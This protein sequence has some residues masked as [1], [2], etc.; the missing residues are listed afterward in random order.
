MKKTHNKDLRFTKEDWSGNPIDKQD[1]YINLDGP[2]ARGF[3]DVYQWKSGK[4]KYAAQKKDQRSNVKVL[5]NTGFLT[6]SESHL[7]WL[8]HATFL[9]QFDGL[10]VITDPILY[11]IWPLKRFTDLPCQPEE[12]IDI[13]IILLSHNHRDHADKKSMKK[14]T[15]QNP[16]AI[17]YT[18]LGI[19]KLLTGWGIKNK[20]V[21]AGWYQEYPEIS[22]QLNFEYLPS[23]RKSVV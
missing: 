17:I 4:N 21:E 11:N 22:S 2:S 6:A 12:L 16:N 13:D 7:T 14:I 8:G 15:S 1:R 23:D 3:K 20:I 18:G 19:G 5:K 9:F 10:K